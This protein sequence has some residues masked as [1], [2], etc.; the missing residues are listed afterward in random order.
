MNDSAAEMAPPVFVLC[1]AR[2]G[3]TLLRLI[4]DTHP[5]V[6]CPPEL[7]LGRACRDLRWLWHVT[8]VPGEDHDRRVHARVRE[9]LSAVMDSYLGRRGKHVFCDTSVSIID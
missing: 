1:C 8:E 5:A 2:S 7:H 4:L 3:S 9:S 6:A